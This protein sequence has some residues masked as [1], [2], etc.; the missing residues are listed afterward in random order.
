MARLQLGFGT[1]VGYAGKN[2]ILPGRHYNRLH[3]REMQESSSSWTKP[4]QRTSQNLSN[5][6]NIYIVFVLSASLL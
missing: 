4:C 2:S 1:K 5:R 3:F 6:E